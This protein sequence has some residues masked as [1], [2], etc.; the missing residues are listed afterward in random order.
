MQVPCVRFGLPP[1][2]NKP[3]PR[4]PGARASLHSE[5]PA[6]EYQI[7]SDIISYISVISLAIV[8]KGH[9]KFVAA[10]RVY[11]KRVFHKPCL[12]A[13]FVVQILFLFA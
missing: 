6:Q 9:L 4:F 2:K 8:L 7:L 11:P 10:L 12:L 1:D 13:W 3:H 5:A